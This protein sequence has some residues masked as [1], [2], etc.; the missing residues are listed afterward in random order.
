MSLA[1][2]WI[3][4]YLAFLDKAFHFSGMLGNLNWGIF[5]SLYIFYGTLS[6]TQAA[7][8]T[9]EAMPFVTNKAILD[10]VELENKS[11]LEW[12]TIGPSIW[13]RVS[14]PRPGAH[15]REI[16][17]MSKILYTKPLWLVLCTQNS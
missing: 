4:E 12:H 15:S 14:R 7:F 3:L 1:T 16:T 10:T 9:K 2:L 5:V 8:D 11:K 17:V 6:S 13:D